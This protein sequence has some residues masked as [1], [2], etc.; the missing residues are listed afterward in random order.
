MGRL[1]VS[2]TSRVQTLRQCFSTF[3][4]QRS[5]PQMFA[6]IMEP[7]AMIHVSILLSVINLCNRGIATTAKNCVCEFRPR[8]FRSVSA[9]TLAAPRQSGVMYI[10]FF[11]KEPQLHWFLV[12]HIL[13][14]ESKLSLGA[15]WWQ[16]WILGPCDNLILGPCDNA[17][18]LRLGAWSA[19]VTALPLAA[20]HE[21]LRFH[22]TGFEKHY[23]MVSIHGVA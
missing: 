14:W 16:D 13:I 9:E 18:P 11:S 4:L 12:L 22:R 23:C 5:L 17:V 2:L 8:Q 15:K 20:P 21:N 10:H 7:S 3:L 1:R 6:L 19:A